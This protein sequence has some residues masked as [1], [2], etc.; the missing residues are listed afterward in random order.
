[1]VNNSV[2]EDLV[3]LKTESLRAKDASFFKLTSIVSSELGQIEV[4]LEEESFFP[5]EVLKKVRDL[6]KLIMIAR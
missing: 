2:L 6:K 4:M 1:M 3:S 5:A